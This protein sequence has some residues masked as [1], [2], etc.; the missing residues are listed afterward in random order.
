MKSLT[1]GMLILIFVF[2]MTFHGVDSS[3]FYNAHSFIIVV[4]G[5]LGIFALS[6][7]P[8]GILNVFKSLMKLSVPDKSVDFYNEQLLAV[9]KKRDV[10]L[11]DSHPL[12]VYAQELWIKGLDSEMIPALLTRRMQELNGDTLRVTS[13]LRN[14]A[15]Y[16]PAMGMTGTVIGLVTLFSHLQPENRSKL[17]PSLALAMTATLYGLLLANAFL[18]PL[19]DRLHLIHLHHSEVNQY[20]CKIL[21]LIHQGDGESIVEDEIND[22]SIS[23]KK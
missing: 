8:V 2:A 19:A 11:S 14:L 7:P 20:I 3:V 4:L 5:T 1:S 6:T 17:G 10:Q 12:I 22:S 13:A 18:M 16:P 9:N 21:L 15:K 23:K